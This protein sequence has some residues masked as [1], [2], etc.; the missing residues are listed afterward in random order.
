MIKIYSNKFTFSVISCVFLVVLMANSSGRGNVSGQAVTGAPGD[1]NNTCATSGCHSSGAFSP[2]A[3]LIVNDANG[4]TVTSFFPGETYDVNLTIQTSGNPSAF[5]FQMVALL[6]DNSPATNW[7]DIGNN[8]Q[9]VT[10]GGR[11][12][13]EHDAPSSSN[14]FTAKWTAP[15]AGSGEVTFYYAA[16]AVNGNGSPSGDGATNSSFVLNESTTS[17]NDLDLEYISVFPN[18]ARTFITIS[19]QKSEYE[20]SLFNLK[21]QQIMTSK[22]SGE[23]TLDIS[24]LEIGLYFIMIE[25]EGD[26]IT[27]K[28][29]KQ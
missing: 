23:T 2:E 9:I 4:N 1:S 7:S 27:K 12:Y 17:S 18:P 6:G 16:N 5:G 11:D 3:N 25:N 8:M 29:I 20:Y 14:E 13:I 19:G 26:I 22:F 21:G 28:V 15:E 24:Q 10:L